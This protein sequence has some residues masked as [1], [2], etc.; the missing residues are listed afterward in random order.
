M[1][2]F[3]SAIRTEISHQDPCPQY[4]LSL[5][6]HPIITLGRQLEAKVV[7]GGAGWSKKGVQYG[8]IL[9]LQSSGSRAHSNPFSISWSLTGQFVIRAAPRLA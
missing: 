8:S 6:Y 1:H 9:L 5:A 2:S 4:F 3:N 7:E